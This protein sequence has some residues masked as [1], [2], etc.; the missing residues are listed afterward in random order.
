MS[1]RILTTIVNV[2]KH[3]RTQDEVHFH[4]YFGRPYPCFDRHCTSPRFDA[5]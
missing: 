4:A 5:G 3:E 2:L 1:R